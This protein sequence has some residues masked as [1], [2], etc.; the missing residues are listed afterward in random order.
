MTISVMAAG[1][2]I[3]IVC[4]V[5]LILI[6]MVIGALIKLRFF[7]REHR[8]KLANVSSSCCLVMVKSD[9]QTHCILIHQNHFTYIYTHCT[10][11]RVV[12]NN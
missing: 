3:G 6:I 9:Q 2:R 10:R 7:A 4:A 1:T 8:L 5:L 11:K 12:P